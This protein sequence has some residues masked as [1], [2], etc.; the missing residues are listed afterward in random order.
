MRV[1]VCGDRH[2][3]D[4]GYIFDRLDD[5]SLYYNIT[6]IIE[7]CA[8]GADRFAEHWAAGKEMP[9][10]HFPADWNR[11]GKAAGIIRNQQML[12]EGKPDMVVAFHTALM[13]SKGTKDMVQ[14]AR[15]AGIETFVFP[16]HE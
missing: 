1:L 4:Y 7:G 11:Y 13:Q 12:D 2:W 8:R 5:M 14:R 15:A 10:Q 3:K 16:H 9:I 6:E